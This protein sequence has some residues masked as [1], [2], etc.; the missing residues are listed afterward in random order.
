[1]Y[2]THQLKFSTM[3][4]KCQLGKDIDKMFLEAKQQF[5]D[6]N[7]IVNSQGCSYKEFNSHLE[8][9]GSLILSRSAPVLISNFQL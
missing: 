7:L 3:K 1:M 6:I 4:D 5:G 9:L 2:K 8:K